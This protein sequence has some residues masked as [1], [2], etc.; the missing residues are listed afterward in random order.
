MATL[1][2]PAAD[3]H[4]GPTLG[5]KRLGVLL[6]IASESVVFFVLIA[7]YVVGQA[8]PNGPTPRAQL[9]VGHMILYSVALWASSATMAMALPR[10][11]R[12]D[13]RGMRWWLLATVV[14]GAIFVIGEAQ[15]W[16]LL[17]QDQI[18]AARNL[19]ATTFFMLTGIHGLHVIIGL[20]AIGTIALVSLRAPVSKSHES[21]LEVVSLYWHFVDAMWI[22]I[23]GTIYVWS[24]V[25]GG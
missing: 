18:S 1:T 13:Q 4:M 8:H 21:G 24:A 15:E 14:L 25:L 23:F 20:I 11:Q 22:L 9:D 7:M 5:P 6:F 10:V 2:I 19:W 12:D 17:Y 16:W 3:T